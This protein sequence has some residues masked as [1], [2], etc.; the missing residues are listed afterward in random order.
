MLATQY[1]LFVD[2]A[3]VPWGGR[4]PRSLTRARIALFL[5][6]E[7]QKDERFFVDVNQIDLFRRRQKKAPLGTRGAPLLLEPPEVV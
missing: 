3:R 4:S 2:V 1:D 7:P 5:R 6:R